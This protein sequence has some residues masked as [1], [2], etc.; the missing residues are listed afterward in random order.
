MSVAKENITAFVL[1]GGQSSRMGQDKGLLMLGKKR[2]VDYVIEA[3][4]PCVREVILIA[5][6][7]AY[8]ELGYQVLEDEEKGQGPLGGI[9]TALKHSPSPYNFMVSC[10]MPFIS[11]EAVR[12]LMEKAGDAD[13]TLPLT[14]GRIQPLCGI[15]AKS[16]LASMEAAL[17][18]GRLQLRSLMK[19]FDCQMLPMEESGL[20]FR[21][22]FKNVNTPEEFEEAKKEIQQ[23]K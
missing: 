8:M 20:D 21:Y 5:N 16:C 2:M 15:Y 7:P 23:W 18:A 3:L 11:R 22:L 12:Y 9:C 10:D 1:A 14:E 17:K 13:V 6:D 19:E 4:E